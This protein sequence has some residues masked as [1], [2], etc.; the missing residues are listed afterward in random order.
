MEAMRSQ[1]EI[2]KIFIDCR[3]LLEGHFLLTSGLHSPR[4]LQCALVLQHPEHAEAF[5]RELAQGF[6]G[7]PIDVVLAPAVGGILVAHEVAKAL[8][9]RALFAERQE[10]RMVLR[11]G[12]RIDPGE[13]VLIVEDVI[14]TG[15]SV[16]ELIEQVGEAGGVVVGVGA[17]VDRSGGKVRFDTKKTALLTLEI[18]T[19]PPE[20]CPLCREGSRPVK[21]GSRR[22]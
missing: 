12:F 16:R 7:D 10:G 4:Y 2:L 5:C 1:D 19:Y 6:K 14:T 11:R 8:K 3:A 13:R 21:P 9:A 17:L 20:A 18:P 15:G 22:R